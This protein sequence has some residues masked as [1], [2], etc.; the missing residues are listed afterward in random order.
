M[1]E[2]YVL[3]DLKLSTVD[4]LIK[5]LIFLMNLMYSFLPLKCF[6]A[7]GTV[8]GVWGRA[9]NGIM[10]AD[11]RGA[12]SDDSELAP[13][14]LVKEVAELVIVL[15]PVVHPLHGKL[16]L[17][18]HPPHEHVVYEHVVVPHAQ[19]VLDA[20]QLELTFHLLRTIQLL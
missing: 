19:L 6:K 16:E 7:L 5:I 11:D 3:I 20:H 13:R 12:L 14:E 10:L 15:I 9:N 18:L 8:I 2:R 1:K 17:A 4:A